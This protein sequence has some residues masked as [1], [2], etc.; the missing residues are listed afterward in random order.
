MTLEK[1]KIYT[2]NVSSRSLG[3]ND[4]KSSSMANIYTEE[5]EAARIAR[6]KLYFRRKPED[7]VK[8]IPK[9]EMQRR[10]K[11]EVMNALSHS[12]VH[13]DSKISDL[14]ANWATNDLGVD[15]QVSQRIFQS[16][17]VTTQPIPNENTFRIR[18]SLV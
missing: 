5:S 4:S 1:Y 2:K 12:K 10:A 15:E 7:K 6:K 17:F 9:A 11:E 14:M 16:A 13:L 18:V 8:E 3:F